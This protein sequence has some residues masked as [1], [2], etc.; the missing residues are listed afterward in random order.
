MP[1]GK[2]EAKAPKKT[3]TRRSSRAQPKIEMAEIE[4]LKQLLAN[5][6][7]LEQDLKR[8]M[9]HIVESRDRQLT[10]ELRR[11]EDR[12]KHLIMWTGV[13]LIMAVIVTFWIASVVATTR[14]TTGEDFTDERYNVEE[15]KKNLTG[16]MDKVMKN[17]E[18]INKESERLKQQSPAPTST[19]GNFQPKLPE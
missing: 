14:R 11:I 2:V 12:N 9:K 17:L 7:D 5:E 15:I 18:E 16:T 19:D 3:V 4:R 6:D 10:K 13:V 1:R 8:E